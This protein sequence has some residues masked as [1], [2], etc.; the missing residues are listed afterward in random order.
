MPTIPAVK[1]HRAKLDW[2]LLASGVAIALTPWLTRETADQTVVANAV[3]AG[4][5]VMMLAELDLVQA[6]RWVAMSQITCCA[7]VSISPFALGYAGSGVLWLW[8]L[9]T[10]LAVL[11]VGGLEL[12][13]GRHQLPRTD[14]SRRQHGC[15]EATNGASEG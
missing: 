4:I 7:W 6:R 1:M 13:Q 5:A 9:A 11:L 3:L 15:E 12:M 10:G 14:R 2:L 8:H